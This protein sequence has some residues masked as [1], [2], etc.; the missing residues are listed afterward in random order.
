MPAPGTLRLFFA[1]QPTAAQNSTLVARAAPLVT[2]LHA[3]R[4]PP[5]NLHATLCF[6]G[7]VA[8]ERL[9]DVR[10]IAA[11][12]RGSRATLRFDA[13]EFWR[14]AGVLCVTALDNSQSEP[15]RVLAEQLATRLAAAGFAPDLKPFR[16]HMTLARKVDHA[17]AAACEWP[18]P[19]TPPF[20]LH[21][22]R[23][24]LM[25]SRRGEGGSI[26]SAVD[27]WALDT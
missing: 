4:V 26:Y 7:A 10:R 15:A 25:E 17:R 21:C 13:F 20:V 5:E 19:L 11:G 22:E 18:R 8:A 14:K 9:D 23:F 1:H 24:A 16:A 3:Q 2:E 12:I 27:S 6:I